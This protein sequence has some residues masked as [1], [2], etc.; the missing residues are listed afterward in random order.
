M[1]R[2]LL[3]PLHGC[4]ARLRGTDHPPPLLSTRSRERHHHQRRL[5]ESEATLVLSGV[6]GFSFK[7]CSWLLFFHLGVARCLADAFD[8][9]ILATVKF[10]GAS[11][12]SLMAA[13]L[14]TK[15]DLMEFRLFA[16]DMV[17]FAKKR[18]TGPCGA[19]SK[20][21]KSGLESHMGHL[22][23][24]EPGRLVV[25]IT[26]LDGLRSIRASQFDSSEVLIASLMSS[27]YI[28][29]Y[30]EDTTVIDNEV[31][32]DGGLTCPSPPVSSDPRRTV[33][34]RPQGRRPDEESPGAASP[35]IG[36]HCYP[37][38]LA[39]V[40]STSEDYEVIEEDGYREASAW[41]SRRLSAS[42]LHCLS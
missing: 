15:L 17:E 3:S 8:P 11:S 33:F 25:S 40:P 26:A 36:G 23:P 18:L 19:M 41:I 24:P 31:C 29:I 9:E 22:P 34:V 4:F 27:C 13:A 14:A 10:G 16:Y 37:R 1:T 20:I 6:D 28:P 38:I 35:I 39:F 7:A 32:V 42:C 2:A 30:Y 21:V 5:T 12:G